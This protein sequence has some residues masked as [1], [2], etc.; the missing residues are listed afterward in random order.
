MLLLV[1]VDAAALL[2]LRERLSCHALVADISESEDRSRIVA[3]CERVAQEPDV[4][5]NNA[6]VEKAS[7]YADLEPAEIRHALEVNLLGAMLLT[8]ELLPGMRARGIGHVINV[9]SMAAVK[10]VP[11]NAVYN[12]AKAGMVASR[13]P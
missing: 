4:L 8:R 9:A 12:T 11:F 3:H 10:T 6:G 1:D 13:C 5:I 2:A 7:E